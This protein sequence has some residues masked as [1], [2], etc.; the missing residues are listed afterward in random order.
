MDARL[1]GTYPPA[2]L[3]TLIS[4]YWLCEV[5]TGAS[6]AYSKMVV[7]RFN[8][9]LTS[10]ENTGRIAVR[11]CNVGARIPLHEQI[12]ATSEGSPCSMASRPPRYAVQ[13]HGDG[14]K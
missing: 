10:L 14:R 12:A 4:R 8:C 7:V 5:S 2:P 13:R 11:L 9:T 3:E 1:G 6:R